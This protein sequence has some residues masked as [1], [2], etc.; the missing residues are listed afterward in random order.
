MNSTVIL[1]ARVG[2]SRRPGKVLAEIAGRTLLDRVMA[3]LEG[4]CG[5]PQVLAIPDTADNDPL[6]SIGRR[7]EWRVFRGSERDV[8]GRYAAAARAFGLERIL[9]ATGDNPFVDTRLVADVD[10]LLP[11]HD[12]VR[13]VGY[14]RGTTVAGVTAR[15]LLE[16]EKEASAEEDREHVMPFLFA[17]PERFRIRVI[18]APV[19]IADRY[20]LT[21]DTEED[22]ERARRIVEALGD[23]PPVERI[24]RFLDE[25]P[26]ARLG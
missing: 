21:V 2:S 5:A 4:A 16:A 3:R 12:V 14:P 25:T 8:L 23:D 6:A 11:G 19:G 9:R 7:R 26:G 1:Q 15:A 24:Y 13:A 20:R 10:S 17:R 22:L 18:E